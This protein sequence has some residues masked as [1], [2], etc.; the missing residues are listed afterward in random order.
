MATSPPAASEKQKGYSAGPTAIEILSVA[1]G[2]PSVPRGLRSTRSSRRTCLGR[3]R[4]EKQRALYEPLRTYLADRLEVEVELFVANNYAGVV[5]A[6]VAKQVDVAYLGGLTYTQAAEQSPGVVPLVTEVDEE[7]GTPRYWAAVV[8]RAEAPTKS[9]ADVVA[10][11]GRFAFG[12]VGSTSGSLYPRMMLV[13]AGAK[14]QP[15]DLNACPP[16]RNVT[17]TGGHDATAQA[18]L[19]SSVEA[20]GLELRILHRLERQGT[21]PK[22]ALRVVEQREVM[23]YPWVARDGLDESARQKVTDAFLAITDPALLSLMRAKSYA[24]V[25]IA[26]YTEVR[27]NAERLGLLTKR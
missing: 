22:G 1:V 13:D 27:Q 20:G 26:D 16:L 18:V 2:P 25:S 19:N 8:V 10:A 15:D 24:A 5:A 7:T 23:G 3:F 12:D 21:V 17:F 14:C 9:V 4:S 11:G 6:L